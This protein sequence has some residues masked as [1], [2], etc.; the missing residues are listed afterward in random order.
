MLSGGR[1]LEA[2]FRRSNAVGTDGA[3]VEMDYAMEVTR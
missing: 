1:A 2:H 3:V